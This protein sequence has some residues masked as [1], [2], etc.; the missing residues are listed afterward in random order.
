[1]MVGNQDLLNI[2]KTA[3]LCSRK[4]SAGAIL[5]CYDWAI[6]QRNSNKCIVSGF[7]SKI[8]KDVLHFLLK[9]DQPIIVVFARGTYKKL[10]THLQ[11]RLDQGNIL[12]ISPFEDTVKVVTPATCQIRNNYILEIAD[13]IVVGYVNPKG[14]LVNLLKHIDKPLKYL[15]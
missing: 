6:E 2:Y 9:G 13:D 11:E 3:F 4:V 12:I 1:M 14:N 15:S 7:H 5:K 8:E 10:D